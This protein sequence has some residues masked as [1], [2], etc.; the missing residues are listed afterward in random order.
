MKDYQPYKLWDRDELY[1]HCLRQM[2]EYGCS[3]LRETVKEVIFSD[4]WNPMTDFNGC[5]VIQDKI[6][7]YIPCLIHDY[8]WLVGEGGKEADIE[9]RNNLEKFGTPNPRRFFMWVGVR[10][11]WFF[12][13]K[14]KE[15]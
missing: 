15:L 6:H 5:S 2:K 4:K 9:F 8:R 3:E 13:M 14:L 11:G 7:P 12:R 10:I 1:V